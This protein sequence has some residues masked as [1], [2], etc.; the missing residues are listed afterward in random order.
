MTSPA[1]RFYADVMFEPR[2][3]VHYEISKLP[4][5]PEATNFRLILGHADDDAG[6]E[7]S[8][9]MPIPKWTRDDEVK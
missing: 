3:R 7:R 8:A 4:D 5:N 6:I 1:G 9:E 2:R